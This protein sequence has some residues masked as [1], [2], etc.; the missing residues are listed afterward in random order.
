M[1]EVQAVPR[2]LPPEIL[3]VQ[4]VSR[5][6]LDPKILLVQAEQKASNLSTARMTSSNTI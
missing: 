2:V 1:L 6:V 4:A 5:V 3:E